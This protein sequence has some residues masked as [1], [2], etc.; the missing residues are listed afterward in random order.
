MRGYRRLEGTYLGGVDR[1]IVFTGSHNYPYPNLQATDETLLKIGSA[2]VYDRFKT[3]FDTTLLG[4]PACQRALPRHRQRTKSFMRLPRG[5]T[6][7]GLWPSP[8]TGR[9]DRT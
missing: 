4:S 8:V 2:A 6:A 9:P 1:K 7:W 5:R 3:N